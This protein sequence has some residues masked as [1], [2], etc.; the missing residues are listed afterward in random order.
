[1]N[2][3]QIENL[4]MTN[5]RAV[6]RALVRIFERQTE[7][8]RQTNDTRVYNMRGFTGADARS[9]SI[10]A[11]YFIKHGSL[12][13]WMLEKWRKPGPKSGKPRIC[14]YVGQI[15]KVMAEDQERKG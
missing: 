6:G 12:Q 4:L 10:T 8:E 2:S 1:M 11:K 9:G 15:L 13:P 5:D 7:D 14:K 3:E